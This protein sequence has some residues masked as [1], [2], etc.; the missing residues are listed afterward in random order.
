MTYQTFLAGLLITR[1]FDLGTTY[2]VTPDLRKE[3]NPLIVLMGWRWTIIVNLVVVPFLALWP[4][5]AV[6]TVL[7]S[8]IGIVINLRNVLAS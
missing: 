8:L 4:A 5:G 7:L 1:A 6:A 3:C 2:L